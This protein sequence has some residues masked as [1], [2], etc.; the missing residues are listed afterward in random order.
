MKENTRQYLGRVLLS[1]TGTVL[2]SFG[3]ALHLGAGK[4]TDSLMVFLDGLS[5]VSQV[6]IGTVMLWFNVVAL[7]IF[8][9]ID[10]KKIGL[11]SL[12]ISVLPSPIVD[13]LLA[14]GLFTPHTLAG[15]YIMALAACIIKGIAIGMYMQPNVGYAPYECLQM[16]IHEKRG[17][18]IGRIRMAMD[19]VTLVL[20]YLMGGVA[21]GGTVLALLIMGPVMGRTVSALDAWQQRR[22]S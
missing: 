5:Q 12:I 20:G 7:T 3:N 14:T 19:A 8:F 22:G 17:Y 9:F 1:T 18:A 13:G 10:R 4:G 6:T 21:G 2:L 11:G 15:A 16:R